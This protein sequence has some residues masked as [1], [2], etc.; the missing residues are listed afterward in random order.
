MPFEVGDLVRC[1]GLAPLREE[2]RLAHAGLA[3][4]PHH[5]PPAAFDLG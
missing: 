2:P 3:H 5:L 1:Q 4:D